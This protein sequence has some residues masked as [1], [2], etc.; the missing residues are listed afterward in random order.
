MKASSRPSF[1]VVS[2]SP[3]PRGRGRGAAIGAQ[4]FA[5]LGTLVGTTLI[6]IGVGPRTTL[7]I[8]VHVGFIAEPIT[9]LAVTIRSS[10]R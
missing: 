7:D 3:G 1:S 8:A 4:A 5:L 2:H 10:P 9:G 6:A